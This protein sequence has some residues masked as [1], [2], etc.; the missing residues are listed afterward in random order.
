MMM[1]HLVLEENHCL[2]VAEWVDVPFITYLIQSRDGR[3]AILSYRGTPPTS[4]ITW[5]T[6]LEVEPVNVRMRLPVGSGTSNDYD[7]HGSFHDNVRSTR[8]QIIKRAQ[9]SDR[10]K[11]NTARR[12]QARPR[13]GG[14][15]PHRPQPRRRQRRDA[16]RELIADSDYQPIVE[17]LKGV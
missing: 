15:V 5:L 16:V 17:N 12:R 8:P 4:L 6:D 3:V 7:V 1:A 13:T 2:K 9:A 10:R 14:A 11:I